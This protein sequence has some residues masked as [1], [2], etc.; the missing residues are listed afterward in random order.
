MLKFVAHHLHR[1]KRG[2]SQKKKQTNKQTT[3]PQQQQQQRNKKRNGKESHTQL[4]LRLGRMDHTFTANEFVFEKYNFDDWI[5]CNCI[6]FQVSNENITV[7][8]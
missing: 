4:E 5:T 3:P 8:I 7:Q 6:Y 2:A 1:S